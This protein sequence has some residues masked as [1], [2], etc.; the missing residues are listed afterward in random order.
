MSKKS[1]SIYSAMFFLVKVEGSMNIPLFCVNSFPLTSS[2]LF[3]SF[4]YKFSL[5]DHNLLFNCF[6][7]PYSFVI[8][9]NVFQIIL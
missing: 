5:V 9:M 7:F 6:N 4:L 1:L 2:V 3:L 8:V